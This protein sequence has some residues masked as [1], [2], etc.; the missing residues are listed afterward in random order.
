MNFYGLILGILATWRLTHL[1]NAEDGPWDILARL[2][3]LAGS[4]LWAELLD[5]F[6]LLYTSD[7][8]DE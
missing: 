2:R 4:G 6:C 5:C 1:L 7:A 3:R 8:A